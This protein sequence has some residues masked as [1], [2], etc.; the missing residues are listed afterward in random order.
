[1]PALTDGWRLVA[2]VVDI[3]GLVVVLEGLVG[4]GLQVHGD[5]A[6]RHH[7]QR[8]RHHHQGGLPHHL[9]GRHHHQGGLNCIFPNC[10]IPNC[11]F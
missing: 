6:G 7:H 11:I 10:I 8:V 1:M 3:G 4:A 2:V 5:L 9:R